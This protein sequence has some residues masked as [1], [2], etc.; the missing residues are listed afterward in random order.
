M[1]TGNLSRFFRFLLGIGAL[2]V[3]GGY[4]ATT[5][6]VSPLGDD[7]KNG[8]SW[9]QSVKSIQ[10]ALD[11]ASVWGDVVVISNGTYKLD[12]SPLVACGNGVT[13]KSFT[14]NPHDVVVDAQEKSRCFYHGTYV[15]SSGTEAS[16]NFHTIRGITFKGGVADGD[17]GGALLWSG[18]CVESCIFTNCTAMGHGGGV[19]LT[20]SIYHI[21]DTIVIDCHSEKN[22]GGI[23]FNMGAKENASIDN[24]F[25]AHCTA[26][27]GGGICTSADIVSNVVVSA[28]SATGNGGGIL[29]NNAKDV[30]L[31]NSLV[32]GN[33]ALDGGGGVLVDKWSSSVAIVDCTVSNNCIA[34][35]ATGGIGGAGVRFENSNE[36]TS[37]HSVRNCLISENRGGSKSVYNGS[38]MAI[39]PC[40]N[41]SVLNSAVI[42]NSGSA[43]VGMF[44]AAVGNIVVSNCVFSGNEQTVNARGGVFGAY[45]VTGPIEII[46]S[47]IVDN[48]GL[49]D[50]GLIEFIESRKTETA[51]SLVFRNCLVA[52]NDFANSFVYSY[53]YGIP[54]SAGGYPNVDVGFENCTFA[55]NSAKSLMTFHLGSVYCQS[56]SNMHMLACA[57]V[58]N[59]VQNP[60]NSTWLKTGN[61][62][63]N[64]LTEAAYGTGNLV[65]DETCTQFAGFDAGDYRPVRGSQLLDKVPAQ[66]WMGAGLK[67]GPH[68]LGR[69]YEIVPRAGYGVSVVRLDSSPRISGKAAEIG[70]CEYY[71]PPGMA[72]RIR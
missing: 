15:T 14:G 2:G 24:C 32:C 29:M 34:P 12:G 35:V 27:S 54:D 62:S 61:L 31:C 16:R 3:S 69:G 41:L 11:K 53:F 56:Q 66:N 36:S 48:K 25:V 7:A 42:N 20:D 5:Y 33:S 18:G 71:L 28:C 50:G 45:N 67:K 65:I 19:W 17:G 26:L 22:G 63:Y 70:C 40:K 57:L 44:F 43:K 9:E 4:A 58:G 51:W 30:L 60:I 10:V 68:D 49:D 37:R 1:K 21:R 46:D 64:L 6:Y 38:G 23:C 52:R 59:S 72:V 8:R 39:Y 47:Y 13:I 55:A